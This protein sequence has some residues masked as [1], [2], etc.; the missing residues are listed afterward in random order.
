MAG[1]CVTVTVEGKRPLVA[2]VQA[3]LAPSHLTS[4]R[5]TTSG[6]DGGRLAMV[7]AVLQRRGGERIRMSATAASDVYASTVGGVR[8]TEP[9][10]DLAVAL[11]VAG[12][13]QNEPLATGLV[14]VGEVGLAGE[15]RRVTATSRRLAEAARLGFTH[16]LVPAGPRPGAAGHHGDRGHRPGDGAAGG[17]PG[18]GGDPVREPTGSLKRDSLV[19]RACAPIDGP[20]RIDSPAV[21]ADERER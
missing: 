1:T 14:A 2:E 16:A 7:L 5:R 11:A 8:L 10:T 9:A 12:A 19:T 20:A 21:T 15:I 3:L 4:P 6:L 13:A 18:G 17:L